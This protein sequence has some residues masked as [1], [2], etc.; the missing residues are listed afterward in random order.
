MTIFFEEKSLLTAPTERV[1]FSDRQAYVCAEM[2]HLAY[3]RFE[4]GHTIDE[5]LEVA[6][7]IFGEDKRFED[8]EQQVR[9]VLAGS[10]EAIIDSKAAFEKILNTAGFELIGTFSKE[11]TQAFLCK[12]L[13][14]RDNAPD[15][16]VIY[17]AFRGTE[18]K[19]FRDIRTDIRARLR[20]VPVEK[21]RVIKLHSGFV[22]ALDLVQKP[23][24]DLLKQTEHDQLIVCGHSL[25]GA[26]GIIFTRLYAK[27]INGACYTFGAPPVGAV[28]VQYGLKTPVYEIVNELDIVPR[29]PNPWLA[30]FTSVLLKT[31]RLLAKSVTFLDKLL[32]AGNWDERLEGFVEMMTEYR[33][34]G[35]M[36]YLVGPENGAR[37]RYNLGSFDKSRLWLKMISKK[38]FSSFS[39]LGS[40]HGIKLYVGKL[41]FHALDRN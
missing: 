14:K 4:G 20:E 9:S 35:Y 29:L 22:D 36:S 41:K 15:K 13:I 39:K 3:F 40:D 2:S 27:G 31:L 1:A 30:G 11:G 23:I 17:L 18:P 33:H 5:V 8:L 38:T 21:D 26:L 16:T 32:A 6:R 10:P 28:D 34:P 37:L 12:R 24:N 7:E 19:D 25:G